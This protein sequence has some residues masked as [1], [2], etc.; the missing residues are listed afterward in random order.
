M[1]PAYPNAHLYQVTQ[2]FEKT[3]LKWWE[4]DLNHLKSEQNLRTIQ[5]LCS[6][7]LISFIVAAM[8]SKM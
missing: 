8:P 6:L 7:L 4:F 5:K 3:F 2:I 1:L